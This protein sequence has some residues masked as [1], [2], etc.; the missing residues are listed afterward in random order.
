MSDET[1]LRKL[2]RP[3]GW[4]IKLNDEEGKGG[5]ASK[6]PSTGYFKIR[7]SG[8]RYWLSFMDNNFEER[9]ELECFPAEVQESEHLPRFNKLEPETTYLRTGWSP[10]V[11]ALTWNAPIEKWK[12]KNGPVATIGTLHAHARN[13]GGAH[14][15]EN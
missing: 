9:G 8:D 2:R 4:K 1:V 5:A 14:G 11:I 3:R 6:L 10:Y 7:I 13:H 12:K 15:I